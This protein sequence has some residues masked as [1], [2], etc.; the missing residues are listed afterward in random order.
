MLN[1][2]TSQET[3]T[4]IQTLLASNEI[5]K[6]LHYIDR[7]GDRTPELR[8]ALG[9]CLMR[10]GETEKAVNILRELVFQKYLSIPRGTPPLYQANYATALLMKRYNQM[11]IEIIETLSPSDHPYIAQLHDTIAQWRNNLPLHRKFLSKLGLYPNA[12]I[13]L[14]FPPG[15]L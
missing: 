14:N 13:V 1:K 15:Q 9:V 3:I 4:Y 12:R 7:K 2:N 5:D 11:A 10:L 6:A 8:N